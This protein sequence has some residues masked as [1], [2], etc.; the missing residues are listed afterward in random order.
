MR[1]P[2]FLRPRKFAAKLNTIGRA[3][4]IVFSMHHGGGHAS[5]R[6]GVA[7]VLGGDVGQEARPPRGQ[8][9]RGSGRFGAGQGR[10]PGNQLSTRQFFEDLKN[11][12]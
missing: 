10:P 4:P 1:A 3:F 11:L 5:C 2:M 9:E 6:A 12:V 7:V 8:G